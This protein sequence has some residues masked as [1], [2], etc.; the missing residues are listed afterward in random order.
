MRNKEANQEHFD[1]QKA[2]TDIGANLGEKWKKLSPEERAP[3]LEMASEDKKRY[4]REMQE[5]NARK[6]NFRRSSVD[7]A[8]GAEA[9]AKDDSKADANS[10]HAED[11]GKDSPADAAEAVESSV[12]PAVIIEKVSADD[13]QSDSEEDSDQDSKTEQDLGSLKRKSDAAS[14]QA[15]DSDGDEHGTTAAKRAKLGEENSPVSAKADASAVA[16]PFSST[17]PALELTADILVTDDDETFIFMIK[18]TLRKIAVQ[19]GVNLNIETASNGKEALEKVLEEKNKYAVVT[20]D[21]ELNSDIDG[22]ET[23]KRMR[24]AGYDGCVVG[25]SAENY[26]DDFG[27]VGANQSLQKGPALVRQ[28]YSMIVEK[29]NEARRLDKA[30]QDA[31]NRAEASRAAAEAKRALAVGASK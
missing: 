30:V 22:I 21:K 10:D 5:Y 7:V 28:V 18:R 2:F 24:Q 9:E 19:N 26:A 11:D 23:I 29:Q 6:H 17:S 1:V 25:V 12:G 14:D 27:A 3:Y 15:A 20:M 8:K 31:I 13:R 16:V 4:E